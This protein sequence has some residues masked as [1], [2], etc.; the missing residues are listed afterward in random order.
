MDQINEESLQ[1]DDI[2][3]GSNDF[4]SRKDFWNDRFTK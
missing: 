3:S 2:P 1:T 4:Y